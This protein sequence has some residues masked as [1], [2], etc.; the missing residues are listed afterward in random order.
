[1]SKKL[2]TPKKRINAPVFIA[3]GTVI[4]VA[5]TVMILLWILAL[6]PEHLSRQVVKNDKQTSTEEIRLDLTQGRF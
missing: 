4:V 2:D 6:A 3:V 1:M 5:L